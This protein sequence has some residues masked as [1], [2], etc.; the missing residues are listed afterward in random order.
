LETPLLFFT[1]VA[2]EVSIIAL[3]FLPFIL[4]RFPIVVQIIGAIFG[5]MLLGANVL[6]PLALPLILVI[7]GVSPRAAEL[8]SPATLFLRTV[9]IYLGNIWDRDSRVDTRID[10]AY[11]ITI[12]GKHY[13]P[14]FSTVCTT[15]RMI[16]LDKGVAIMEFNSYPTAIGGTEA[17]AVG[18]ALVAVAQSW[19]LCGGQ[20]V[21]PWVVGTFA[22]N[23]DN[24]VYRPEL[25][26]VYVLDGHADAMRFYEFAYRIDESSIDG[27]ALSRPKI[28]RVEQIPVKGRIS[29]SGMWPMPRRGEAGPEFVAR[30]RESHSGCMAIVNEDW[31]SSNRRWIWRSS[32]RKSFGQQRSDAARRT[33]CARAMPSIVP[34]AERRVDSAN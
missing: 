22:D 16:M 31:D 24:Q 34:V 10:V 17:V 18:D 6:P 7:H 2:I 28:L 9:P 13:E 15:R 27:I 19:V 23:A 12:G 25:P 32:R 3:C 29:V 30:L 5:A 4:R 20:T 1:L 8:L 11:P 14:I 26:K 21:R 33:A